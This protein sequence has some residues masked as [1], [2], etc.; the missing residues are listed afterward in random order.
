MHSKLTLDSLLVLSQLTGLT[1]LDMSSFRNR[2]PM[3]EGT[4]AQLQQLSS[5][6]KLQ[7]LHLSR[8]SHPHGLPHG[9][10]RGV[11]GMTALTELHFAN[12]SKE[13]SSR[14]AGGANS[15]EPSSGGDSQLWF[16]E[17][18]K[19]LSILDLSGWRSARAASLSSLSMLTHLTELKLQR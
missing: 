7:A 2:A 6:K 12:C 15:V 18:L 10:L 1:S 3:T 8:F 5:L 17:G 13:S 11:A 14:S 4:D 16:L 19:Q 9:L